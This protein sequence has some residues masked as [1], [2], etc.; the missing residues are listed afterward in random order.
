M[1]VLVVHAHP[2]RLWCSR[3]TQLISPPPPLFFF[4]FFLRRQLL[5]VLLLDA[6]Q[7]VGRDGRDTPRVIIVAAV[8]A[9]VVVLG[10]QR[11]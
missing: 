10:T 1:D 4:F 5:L 8:L 11:P 6:L 7:L 2:C 9:V 3:S